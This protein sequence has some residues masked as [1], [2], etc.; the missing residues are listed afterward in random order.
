MAT[1]RKPAKKVKKAAAKVAAPKKDKPAKKPTGRPSLRTPEVVD[2]IIERLSAGEFLSAICRD[3]AMPC[4]FAVL[5]WMNADDKLYQQ[6]V[7]ARE[8]GMDAILE[9]ARQIADTPMMGE[10]R[11]IGGPNGVEVTF[12]DM[13]GHRKLQIETRLR[14]AEKMFPKKY[15][16]SM[17]LAGDP[18]N[19]TPIN[20]AGVVLVP[21]KVK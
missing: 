19:D 2:A 20:V 6:I 12:E 1:K 21:P 3:E 16:Q 17:K 15:G 8:V 14:L 11:K 18:N 4:R 7:H 10:R 9:E 13:L 5:K